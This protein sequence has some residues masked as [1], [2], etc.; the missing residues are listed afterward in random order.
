MARNRK[1]QGTI[2]DG[3]RYDYLTMEWRQGAV[4][5]HGWGEYPES[6]VLAGQPMKRFLDSFGTVEEAKTAYP[7]AEMSHPLIQAQNSFS[8]LPGEDDPVPGGMYPDD[9]DT[10]DRYNWNEQ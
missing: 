8:H 3:E 5:V 1:V 9:Y 4:C 2:V 6:S 10:I 7:S